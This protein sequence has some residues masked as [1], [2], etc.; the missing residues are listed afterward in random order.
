MM[1]TTGTKYGCSASGMRSIYTREIG[2]RHDSED[3]GEHERHSAA[4]RERE[5][6]DKA[7]RERSAASG[8]V[9]S[10]SSGS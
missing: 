2:D 9:P 10:Y 4:G 8:R 3:R 6:G 5:N 1:R 7:G